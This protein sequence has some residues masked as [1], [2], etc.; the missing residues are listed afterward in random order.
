[1]TMDARGHHARGGAGRAFRHGRRARSYR[2]ARRMT[3]IGQKVDYVKRAGQARNHHCHWPGCEKQV[4]PAMWGCRKH[5]Y[6]LPAR[7]RSKIW[8]RFRPGQEKPRTPSRE[9]LD[10]AREVQ[11]WIAANGVGL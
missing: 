7:L 3:T 6:A 11:E 10:A 4:P 1:R 2:G 8:A 5:W 9:Y